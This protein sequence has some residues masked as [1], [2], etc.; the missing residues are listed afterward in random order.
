MFVHEFD[1]SSD[2]EAHVAFRGTADVVV[3]FA[4]QCHEH[5]EVVRVA[6]R[7]G[8]ATLVVFPDDTALAGM[9]LEGAAIT[10]DGAGREAFL[11]ALVEVAQTARERRDEGVHAYGQA[12]TVFG[13]LTLPAESPWLSHGQDLAA[14]SP[15]EHAVLK[16]LVDAQGTVV[17]KLVLR[18]CLVNSVEPASDGYLKAVVLRIR[19]KVQRLGGDA[20]LLVAVRGFGYLLKV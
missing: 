11:Q 9:G 8:L 5:A 12:R 17:P 19:K 4:D 16:V 14:L 7:R 6:L 13:G 15:V 3:I 1:G 18:Q 10:Y 20:S 2:G